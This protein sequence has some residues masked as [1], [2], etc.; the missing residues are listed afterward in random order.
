[1]IGKKTRRYHDVFF[2][3]SKLC[4]VLAVKY[5]LGVRVRAAYQTEDRVTMRELAEKDYPAT[6]RAIAVYMKTFE[7]QWMTE[8]KPQGFDVQHIRLG[9]VK[10]RLDYCRR[11]LLAYLDGKLDKIDELETDILPI[12][13]GEPGQSMKYWGVASIMTVSNL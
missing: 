4:S 9:G 2:A 3:A 7:K 5:D 1:L 11:T 13:S 6:I 10:T 8:N 12:G